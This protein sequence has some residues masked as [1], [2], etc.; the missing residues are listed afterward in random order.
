MQTYSDTPRTPALVLPAGACDSHVHVFGPRA[1]FPY[2]SAGKSTPA[3]APKEKL[4][5]L[6]RRMGIE[7][8]VIVQSTVHGLDNRVV[9]DA[10]DAGGG[11]YLGIALVPPDVSD[12]ELLRLAERGFRGVRFNFMRHLSGG[13][14]VTDILALTP[15][16][17][18]VGM[19]LQVHFESVLMHSVG[20]A[21][22][23]SQVPVVI[24]HMG[25]IDAMLGAGH[26]DFRALMAL[27]EHPR[28]HVKVSGIDRI[29]SSRHAG[30]G[31]P[32]GVAMARLL[33]ERFPERCVWGL[34]W[35]H[36]NHTHIP[37]DGELIDALAQIA[38]DAAHL[39]SLL[40]DNPQ[41]LYGFK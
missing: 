28:M 31:Y 4:F 18:A 7:R 10:I 21:L 39:K 24:D 34:D 11:R 30:S 27:L 37:D 29:D 22:R 33:V 9:E 16:L 12:A 5:A 41:S 2:A 14:D 1:R 8:C 3:E 38:P 15:R 6:H 36:P 17:A 20:Q 35:P 26:P 40:V 32:D 13:A 25:R 19:H 23:A